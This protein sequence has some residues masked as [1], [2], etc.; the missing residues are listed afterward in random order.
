MLQNSTNLLS[1]KAIIPALLL[2][3][4][5]G[6][7]AYYYFLFNPIP[8]RNIQAGYFLDSI[9]IPFDWSQFGPVSFP[10]LVDNFLIFQEFKDLGPNI[11]VAESLFF[12]IL[13]GL[14]LA[15]ILTLV[16]EL[17]KYFFLA[18]GIA[19]I[20]ILTFSNLN[21]LNIGSPSSNYPLIIAI[22]GTL[23]IPVFFHITGKSLRF[24]FRFLL[25]LICLMVTGYALETLSP[26]SRPE[27]FLAEHLTMPA[28]LL[29]IAW[30]LW[31]GHGVIS[32]IYIL[33]LKAGRN[34]SLKVSIQ[35]TLI[36]AV[37][38]LLMVNILMDFTGFPMDFLPSFNPL[39][40]LFPLGI[41]GWF[42]LK[43]R[44]ESGQDLVGSEKTLKG[45]YLIG[46][47]LVLWLSWKLKI[48]GN[49]PAEEFLKHIFTYSQIG[50]SLFFL[51]YILTN[52]YEVMNSGKAAEKVLFKPHSLPYYHLR[53]GGLIAMLVATA[54]SE[55]IV[56]V[57]ANAMSSNI[58]GD[59]YY[60]SG[61]KLEASIIYENSWSRYRNNP[62]AKNAIA[63][64]LFQLNQPTLA[65]QHLEESF[66][67]APQV[68]NIILLADRLHRENK[69][70]ESIFYLERGL[71]FFPENEL[72][73][74][75]L[76]LLLTKVNRAEEALAL[77]DSS[78]VSHP[79]SQSNLLALKAKMGQI[80]GESKA[81]NSLAEKINEIARQN[82]LGNYPEEKL[83]AEVKKE[84]E[85]ENSPLLVQAAWRNIFSQKNHI[86][87][88]SDIAMLDSLWKQEE[89]Q[90]YIMQ[91]QETAVIRSLGSGK[92]ADA[93][94]NLNGL[95]FRN[96][97]DAGYFLHLSTSILAQQMDFK[98]AAKELLAAEEK[99]FQAFQSYHWSILSFGGYYENAEL[100]RVKYGLQMPDYLT[101][102][103][104]ATLFYLELIQKFHE[105]L[106]KTLYDEWKTLPDSELKTDFAIRLIAFK[107]HGIDA[108]DLRE[109]GKH[110][111]D[112][113]GIQEDLSKFLAN[114]DLKNKESVEALLNWLQLGDELTGNPYFSPLIWSA[115]A[116]NPDPLAQY[117]IINAAT[118][119]NRD[120]ILWI[121]KV[122]LARAIG[123][124]NYATDALVEMAQWIDPAT[125]ERLQL[126]N[127]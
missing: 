76:A 45:M 68:D 81:L 103:D 96:P 75:N 94:K 6:L 14:I 108:S 69:I 56:G 62:K 95:A 33:L 63:H 101:Q 112:K 110:I 48:S 89:M 57:Q 10:I 90:D 71:R 43:E 26:I 117:E 34:L 20:A 25:N 80:E 55:G 29:S 88:E 84:I 22:V 12:G 92:I 28:I 67:E 124:S 8:Y 17:K 31:N 64:L 115:V 7:F 79:V 107:S 123:L 118:E 60:G 126:T 3:I 70:F 19:W 66:S 72:L 122:Q 40:L 77:L 53:I 9:S 35:I 105:S 58:L 87:I 119:F 82:A 98:K 30:L 65:K 114:P 121:K 39:F 111:Q 15:L 85:K 2:I 49:Q 102:P 100:I 127:Y 52:F 42:T 99:G 61:Q 50:F 24:E 47:G 109:L 83:L 51:V 38:L 16:S 41:L 59:Y 5:G 91:L 32:G 13:M 11:F 1:K 27:L 37:Y 4:T 106:P 36:T 104:E 116:I 73:L 120:P 44:V 21:G 86:N 97:G 54:Y 113:K 23:V 18:F 93:V 46:F 125:L 78:S 74:N